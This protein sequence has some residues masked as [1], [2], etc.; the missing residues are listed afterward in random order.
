MA[1][2][3]PVAP[4]IIGSK[5]WHIC[6]PSAS[7]EN[8]TKSTLSSEIPQSSIPWPGRTFIIRSRK[9]GQ[10]ITFLDGEVVMD[11]LGGLGTFRWRCVEEKGWIG[12]KDPASAQYL[13]YHEH[14]L[15]FCRSPH[16]RNNEYICPRMRPEGGCVLLVIH[17]ENL[18]PLGVYGNES[19]NGIKQKIKINMDWSSEEIV[20]DF[21]EVRSQE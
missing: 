12:F 18:R 13:G 1:H 15:L 10:V 5:T 20:W 9:N 17:D 14:G 2:N 21:I 19:E 11:K 16:H 7:S 8:T 3:Q 4:S 6:T